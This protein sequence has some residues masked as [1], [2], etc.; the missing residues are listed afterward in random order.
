MSL[1]SQAYQFEQYLLD[2]R[3]KEERLLRETQEVRDRIAC[4]EV[5]LEGF[6]EWRSH[7]PPTDALGRHSHISH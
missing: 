4:V 7:Q 6:L 2:L 5:A 1:Q 3:G